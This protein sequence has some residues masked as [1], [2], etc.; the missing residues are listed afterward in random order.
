MPG[1]RAA[2]VHIPLEGEGDAGGI[3]GAGRLQS[4]ERR[5]QVGLLDAD[6]LA[7]ARRRL[8]APTDGARQEVFGVLRLEDRPPPGGEPLQ[9]VCAQALVHPEPAAPVRIGPVR[10]GQHRAVP[11]QLERADV[12]RGPAAQDCLDGLEGEALPEDGAD[13][14]HVAKRPVEELP[15]ASDDL[16]DG[17]RLPAEGTEQIELEPRRELV[18]GHEREPRGGQLDRRRQR[19]ELLDDPAS[20]P[21]AH[22]PGVA[23]RLR[24]GA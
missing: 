4:L 3:G 23:N 14:E 12:R 17:A 8:R 20:G 13:R 18:G 11:E 9:H 2:H 1:G 24:P 7:R 16:V 21:V 19:V 5:P 6:G 10:E 22:A 15:R